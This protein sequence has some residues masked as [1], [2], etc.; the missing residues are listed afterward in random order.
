MLKFLSKVKLEFNALESCSG[1]CLEIL[2]QC[3]AARK[4]KES[5]PTCQLEVKRHTDNRPPQITVTFVN[6][7]EVV[8]DAAATS[9][10]SIHSSILEKGQ[11]LETEKMF[12]DAGEAWPVIIPEEELHQTAPGSKPRKAE[13]QQQ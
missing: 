3:T 2:S 4:D 6:G 1:A 10:Q 13:E 9:A 7:E 12:R 8:F 5:N 11:L